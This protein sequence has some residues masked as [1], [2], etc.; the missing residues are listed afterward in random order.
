MINPVLSLEI[1]N[2][3]TIELLITCKINK[4]PSVWVGTMSTLELSG[5]SLLLVFK[6]G[7]KL[8]CAVGRVNGFECPVHII[9]N[10]HLVQ[11]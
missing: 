11:V 3:L 6:F 4:V 5:E 2:L 9:V 10:E 7:A 1:G 8:V